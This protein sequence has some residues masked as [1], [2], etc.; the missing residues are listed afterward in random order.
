MRV[1]PGRF[2]CRLPSLRELRGGPGG[3]HGADL[4][5]DLEALPG[6]NGTVAEDTEA[7]VL[8]I[9]H[10]AV[11][12]RCRFS[13]PLASGAITRRQLHDFTLAA[14]DSDLGSYVCFLCAQLR[15][16]CPSEPC[17]RGAWYP[18]RGSLRSAPGSCGAEPGARGTPS[19]GMGRASDGGEA[20]TW[21]GAGRRAGA[22]SPW[23]PKGVQPL[24]GP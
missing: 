11:A 10:G 15:D 16:Y 8:A 21:C 17:H 6:S 19:E 23:S 1:D 22:S 5:R 2:R 18:L 20:R 4:L 3:R 9:Y 24:A 12:E 13:A 7:G 14:T